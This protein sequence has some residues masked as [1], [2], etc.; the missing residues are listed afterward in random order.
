MA[1][2]EPPIL[3]QLVM[4]AVFYITAKTVLRMLGILAG[5][6]PMPKKI[7]FPSSSAPK[8]H[9]DQQSHSLSNEI[10]SDRIKQAK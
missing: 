5:K 8:I 10:K 6:L 7:V 9:A 1:A 3:I 2:I 4:C